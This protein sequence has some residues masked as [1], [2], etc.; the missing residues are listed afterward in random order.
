MGFHQTHYPVALYP[1]HL[2]WIAWS[3]WF[4]L[5]IWISWPSS[6]E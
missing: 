5:G 1:Y 4:A 6:D 3:V 2:Y